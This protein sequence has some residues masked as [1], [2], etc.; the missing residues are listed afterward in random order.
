MRKIVIGLGNILRGDDGLG[1]FVFEV[2][3][4][5]GLPSKNDFDVKIA[6]CDYSFTNLQ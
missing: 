5:L 1:P 6:D 2:L 3:K 4:R